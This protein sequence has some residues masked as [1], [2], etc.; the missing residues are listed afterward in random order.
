MKEKSTVSKKTVKKK[1][2]KNLAARREDT[3]TPEF[4]SNKLPMINA[5]TRSVAGSLTNLKLP[6]SKSLHTKK[7]Q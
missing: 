4:G 7:T 1:D 6:K 5:D 2:L 3:G